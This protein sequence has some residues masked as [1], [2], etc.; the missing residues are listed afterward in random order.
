MPRLE[1][2]LAGAVA[3]SVHM[4]RVRLAV[5]AMTLLTAAFAADARAGDVRGEPEASSAAARATSGR[6]VTFP[7]KQRQYLFSRNG[8]GGLAYLPA[9]ATAAGA[10]SSRALPVVVFLH[11]MNPEA[12]VH[13]WFGPP[14]GDLRPVADAIVGGGAA[15]FV[16]AAPTHARY[17]T[18]AAVMW[19]DFDLTDFLDTTEHALS[20]AGTGARFDRGRVIVV[21]HSGGGC[22]PTGG[23]FSE[24]V[25]AARPL[26]VLAIDTC[27][28]E[29]VTPAL[30]ELAS[31]APVRFYWQKTWARPVEQLAEACSTCAV[32]E[33]VGLG[34]T[35]HERILPEVLRRALPELL[36]GSGAR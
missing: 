27:V 35:G 34:A 21:G 5:L 31:R 4:K 18:A 28:D 29:K 2:A 3:C 7:Y 1:G 24:S 36:P 19:H 26:A 20:E 9:G 33:I 23:L 17:A 12:L 10:T 15:P 6:T 32:E 22:N 16:L 30:T 13:M 14:Y 11:G 8:P 25:A